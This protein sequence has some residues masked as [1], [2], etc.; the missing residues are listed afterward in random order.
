M[1]VS[2]RSPSG[3][4]SEFVKPTSIFLRSNRD[5]PDQGRS[6]FARS[7]PVDQQLESPSRQ[8]ES[9]ARGTER[10]AEHLQQVEPILQDVPQSLIFL[11]KAAT[12]DDDRGGQDQH[13][14]QLYRPSAFADQTS[15]G[16]HPPCRGERVHSSRCRD[17]AR[18]PARDAE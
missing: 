12:Q 14:T 11:L 15:A 3:S 7:I 16:L 5:E 6:S 9:T 4:S 1:Q 10:Q 18:G 17:V 2:L 8:R 13:S